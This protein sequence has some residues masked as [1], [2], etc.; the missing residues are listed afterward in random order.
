MTTEEELLVLAGGDKLYNSILKETRCLVKTESKTD[1]ILQQNCANTQTE[2]G[3][4]NL[5]YP[6]KHAQRAEP[7]QTADDTKGITSASASHIYFT[8]E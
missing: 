5:L 6:V 4:H 8:L 2:S 1:R 3:K 7:T